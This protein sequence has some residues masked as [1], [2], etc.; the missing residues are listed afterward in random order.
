MTAYDLILKKRNGHSHTEEELRFLLEQFTSGHVESYQMS[1]WLMAVW[2]RGMSDEETGWLTRLMVESGDTVDLSSIPGTKVDKHSTGGVGDTTT[3]VLAPLA[4]AAGARVAKMSGRG[5]GHTGGTL[6]KLE[7]IPGMRVNLTSQ[8]FLEQVRRIGLAVISQTADLVPA[9][10]K[11]YAL[12]DVT[13]TVDSIPLIASSVMSKKI[14]CGAEAIL[15][16]VKFGHGAFMKTLEDCRKLAHAM[17]D[18][19]TRLGRRVRAAL[20][21]MDQPLGGH[22]GNSLEVQEAIDILRGERAD[23]ALAR[24]STELAS[25]LVEMAGCAEN[26]DSAREKVRHLIGT[27]AAASKLREFIQAQGGDPAVVDDP[28]R[29]PA[30]PHRE[31]Y[32]APSSGYV[33]ALRAETLGRAAMVL[34]AGRLKKSDPIDPAVGLVLHRRVGDPVST[35]EPILTFHARSADSVAAA[36]RLVEEAVDVVDRRPAERPLIQEFVGAPSVA[37]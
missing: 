31:D 23:S 14:A 19:G 2:F 33:G 22:I 9:D 5:L 8:E 36:R 1:A 37:R 30:A 18:I 13:A 17:V 32:L 7:S 24:V 26:L 34:G 20:S 21:D 35:G 12:R 3:L 25:H 10:G 11:I 28:T 29:M 15:L 27:G 6:D 16:D 4:A